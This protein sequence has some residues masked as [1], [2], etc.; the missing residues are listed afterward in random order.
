MAP[1]L[2]RA[3]AAARELLIDLAA[4]RWKVDRATLK[5]RRRQNRRVR[6]PTRWLRR[7]QQ[8]PEA[9]RRRRR[10]C[11]RRPA[12]RLGLRGKP[13]KKINGRDFV[14]GTHAYTPDMTR[15][16]M[17]MGRVIRPDALGA[18]PLSV[19]DSR[20]KAMPGVT[21]VRDGN[22][23]GVV[24]PD[25]RALQAAAAAVVVKWSDAPVQPS[26]ETDVRAPEESAGRPA[27]AGAVR[28]RRSGVTSRRPRGRG[29][30]SSKPATGFRTSRTS[31]SNRARPSPNGRTA[32]S[33]S[34]PARSGRSGFALK[35]P[36]HFGWPKI[37]SA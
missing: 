13:V 28:R 7:A 21:V 14:T 37:A 12:R 6:R 8:R 20:A 17:L 3:A 23:I 34:G 11:P 36:K 31:R 26:S 19:D 24:A 30:R 32:K 9:H 5:A 15:P 18:E 27:R 16:Q 4:A 22:F 10:R 33:R 2:A 1:Q 29:E 35:S 25:E